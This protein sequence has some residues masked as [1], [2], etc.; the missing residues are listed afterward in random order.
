[1]NAANKRMGIALLTVVI[2][3]TLTMWIATLQTQSTMTLQEMVTRHPAWGVAS[4]ALFLVLVIWAMGW[5]DMGFKRPEPLSSLGLLWLPALYLIALSMFGVMTGRF[6]AAAVAMV[7]LNTAMVGFSEELAFRGVLWGAARKA[8][9]FWP[10]FLLVSVAFGSL[11]ILN[12]LITGEFAG[13]GIQALNAFMSGV[14]YLA[15]RIRTRSIIPIMVIHA[16]W[17]F[18]VFMIGSGAQAAP[19]DPS[20]WQEQLVGGLMLVGPLFVYGLW[21]VRN[22]RV[23]AG[24]R[25]D[26]LGSPHFTAGETP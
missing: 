9:P 15:I 12:T 7:L 18:A 26:S 19:A 6:Q 16:A 10:G 23:R 1:M 13:A 14:A 24:W 3:V 5:R 4:A 21:L 25:N 17:D 11:H 2:W 8:L 20:G 22:Q